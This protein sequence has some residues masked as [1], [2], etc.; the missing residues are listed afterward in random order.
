MS[1]KHVIILVFLLKVSIVPSVFIL[2]NTHNIIFSIRLS[3]TTL[4]TLKSLKM[5]QKGFIPP[6]EIWNVNVNIKYILFFLI[7][8]DHL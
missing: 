6:F 4:G 7:L 8:I 3:D 2:W 1:T 5:S